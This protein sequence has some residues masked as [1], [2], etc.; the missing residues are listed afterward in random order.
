VSQKK[1]L[2][3][4]ARRCFVLP[5]SAKNISYDMSM[6]NQF[7]SLLIDHFQAM[8]LVLVQGHQDP[9]AIVQIGHHIPVVAFRRT[10]GARITLEFGETKQGDDSLKA[11]TRP[12]HWTCSGLAKTKPDGQKSGDESPSLKFTLQ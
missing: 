12:A 5:V 4:F 9:N 7:L 3:E 11:N 10:C 2:K 8:A 1:L 6:L